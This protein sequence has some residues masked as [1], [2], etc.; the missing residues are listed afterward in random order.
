M[1]EKDSGGEELGE[2]RR[3]IRDVCPLTDLLSRTIALI[4]LDKTQTHN[5]ITLA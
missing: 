2:Y 4:V 1:V 5:Q 3:Y